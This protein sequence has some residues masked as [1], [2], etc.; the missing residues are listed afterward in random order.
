M[1]SQTAVLIIVDVLSFSTAVDIATG[2]GASVLPFA[3]GN[4]TA[5]QK[6]AEREGAVL[7]GPRSTARGQLS[8]SPHSLM[9]IPEGTRLML[10]SPNGS[11]LSL[12]AGAGPVLTGCFRNAKAAACAAMKL[13]NGGDIGIIPAG[14][15]WPDGSL[16]PA[17]EDMLCAGA[18]IDALQCEMDAEARLAWASYSGVAGDLDQIIKASVSGQELI[19]SG[20]SQDVSLALELSVS[21]HVAILQDGAYSPLTVSLTAYPRSVRLSV[22]GTVFNPEVPGSGKQCRL[23][24]AMPEI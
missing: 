20:Y 16:R 3:Y 15:R 9:Q 24:V 8:L 10:P 14:E 21:R 4:L 11:R 17:I 19:T 1:R 13:S 22:R 23:Q 18:I 5:A 2:C 7:A 12:D 6:A